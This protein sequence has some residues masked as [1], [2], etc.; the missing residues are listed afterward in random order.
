VTLF[1]T[2]TPNGSRFSRT[3]SEAERVGWKRWLAAFHLW[4]DIHFF[5]PSR[6]LF[7]LNPIVP[8]LVF[9]Q[10]HFIIPGDAVPPRINGN[11][12]EEGFVSQQLKTIEI[13]DPLAVVNLLHSVDKCY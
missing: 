12:L 11:R 13:Q 9:T 8:Q 5:L 1:F 7:D 10:I 4:H 3:R 2:A 6:A